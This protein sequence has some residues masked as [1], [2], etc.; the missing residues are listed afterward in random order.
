MQMF[1]PNIFQSNQIDY[2]RN[3]V[4]KVGD[5]FANFV[6]FDVSILW[7]LNVRM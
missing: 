5:N 6:P 3:N 4:C 2:V 7:K 1:L